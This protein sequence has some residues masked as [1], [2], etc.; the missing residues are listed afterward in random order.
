[1]NFNKCNLMWIPR[2]LNN[3]SRKDITYE[4]IGKGFKAQLSV[5]KKIHTDSYADKENVLH[6]KNILKMLAD[7]E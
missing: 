2:K 4:P 1:M 5:G 3:W 6:E 7:D